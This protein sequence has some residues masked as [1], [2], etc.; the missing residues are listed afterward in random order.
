MTP[1]CHSFQSSLFSNGLFSYRAEGSPGDN[2][3]QTV[4]KLPRFIWSTIQN[5]EESESSRYVMTASN[6]DALRAIKQNRWRHCTGYLQSNARSKHHSSSGLPDVPFLCNICQAKILRTESY[7]SN[8]ETIM[9]KE[10]QYCPGRKS[11]NQFKIDDPRSISQQLR[12][13]LTENHL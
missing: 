10:R 6:V 9:K 3:Q 7:P 1:I 11:M 2:A 12:I 13:P 8:K 5:A 4:S